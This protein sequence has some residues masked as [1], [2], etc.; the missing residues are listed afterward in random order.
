[1]TLPPTKREDSPLY[2]RRLAAVKARRQK[3]QANQR[4]GFV[5]S[6]EYV[7]KVLQKEA[8]ANGSASGF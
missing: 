1:M 5:S 2:R 6:C 7:A 3:N 4:L 8:L